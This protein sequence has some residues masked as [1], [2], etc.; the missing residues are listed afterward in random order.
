MRQALKYYR[1]NQERIDNIHN[2]NDLTFAAIDIWTL[3]QCDKTQIHK[4]LRGLYRKMSSRY[5]VAIINGRPAYVRVSDHW[6]Y[7]TTRGEW[8]DDNYE[9]KINPHRWE[10]DGGKR[11]ADGEYC[12]TSQAGYIYLD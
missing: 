1:D 9:Y 8:D 7:F 4:S 3:N 10:L 12:K 11:R 6:G 5:Y 2:A